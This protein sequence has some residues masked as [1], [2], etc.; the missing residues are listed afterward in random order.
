MKPKSSNPK[1]NSI[2][3]SIDI[4]KLPWVLYSDKKMLPIHGGIYFVGTDEE[5][6]AYIGQAGCL[7]TRFIGHH[8]EKSFEELSNKGGEKNVRIRYWQ[9]PPMSKNELMTFLLQ[10]E[11]LLIKKFKPRLN[12]TAIPQP[13]K[14]PPTDPSNQRGIIYKGAV[15]VQLNQLS[16]YEYDISQATD[17]TAN[18]YFS[19]RKLCMAEKAVKFKS[20]AFLIS[21][22]SWEDAYYSCGYGV[23]P[24]WKQYPTL[25]FLE[26]R[27]RARWIK[28]IGQDNRE[29][30]ML[31]GDQASFHRVFLNEFPGFKEFSIKYLRTG[32]TNCSN[33]DFC[34][35]LLEITR[36][37]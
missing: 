21:S 24:E 15:Y 20:P 34:R 12:Y 32:L 37:S 31:S 6:T 13:E 25:Y 1:V 29:E 7:K 36:R 4:Q 18:F 19:A 28:R 5:P 2:A 22:G 10:I 16:E 9:A 8:R 33:S 27:F 30:F 26:A 3:E 11:T 17:D 35:T 14:L 23:K